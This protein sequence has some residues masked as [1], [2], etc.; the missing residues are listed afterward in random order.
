MYENIIRVSTYGKL[1]VKKKKKKKWTQLN[2]NTPAF[3]IETAPPVRRG[4]WIRGHGADFAPVLTSV[5]AF[6]AIAIDVSADV[7]PISLAICASFSSTVSLDRLSR[8]SM[9]ISFLPCNICKRISPSE[10]SSRVASKSACICKIDHVTFLR[11]SQ[12][13]LSR[14]GG[15]DSRINI[16]LSLAHK[17]VIPDFAARTLE[18]DR[19]RTAF[20]GNEEKKLYFFLNVLETYNTNK[21]FHCLI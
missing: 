1:S 15:H 11:T 18:S 14:V 12:Y 7:A 10:Y 2:L 13:T 16:I 20:S 9:P 5:F 19:R 17:P 6:I 21:D 4:G 3:K 8:C